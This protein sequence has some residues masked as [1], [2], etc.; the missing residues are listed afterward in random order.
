[1]RAKLKSLLIK[2]RIIPPDTVAPDTAPATPAAPIPAAPMEVNP[3]YLGLRE[4][5]F[6][7]WFNNKTDELYPGMNVTADDTVLDLGCGDG[8]IT[9]FCAQR[10]PDIVIA[11]IDGA[12]LESTRQ[13]LLAA[14][15]K[16]V[17]VLVTDANPLPLPDDCMTRV[18]CTEVIEH[19]DDPAAVL[20][21]LVRVG[22]PG[23]IYLISVPDP[24]A[25]YLQKPIAYPNY[26]E[27]PNHIRIIGRDEFRAMVETSGLVVDHHTTSSFYW[28]IWW[29]FYWI[30]GQTTMQGPWHPLLQAW[31]QAW[32]LMLHTPKGPILKKELDKLLAK[33]Q[34]IVARKPA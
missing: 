31:A 22:K 34:I 7:G 26:F 33:S 13:R 4:S 15:A 14:N 29:S 28:A 17:R 27:K 18:I 25:E 16:S 12:K 30:C 9:S 2:A 5:L 3:F 10:G 21:E 1:M 32:E 23:A 8:G 20:A 24:T 11:D 6:E 19:V